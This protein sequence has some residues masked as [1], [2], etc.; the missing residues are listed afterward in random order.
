[1]GNIEIRKAEYPKDDNLYNDTCA[2]CGV[3]C[4]RAYLTAT[5]VK[6]PLCADCMKK[7]AE[8]A[9]QCV[10]DVRRTCD[11]CK[12]RYLDSLG[13]ARCRLTDHFTDRG[14]CCDSFESA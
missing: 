8:E 3:K 14:E 6:I 11:F 13:D 12:H 4:V 7:F 10:D 2:E 5:I 1:M 9:R